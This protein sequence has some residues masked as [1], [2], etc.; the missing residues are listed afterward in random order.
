[1]SFVR[2]LRALRPGDVLKWGG[3]VFAYVLAILFVI[4]VVLS[5]IGVFE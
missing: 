2:W 1:M 5:M 4:S 3:V